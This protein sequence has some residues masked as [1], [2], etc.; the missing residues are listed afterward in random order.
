MPKLRTETSVDPSLGPCQCTHS[1]WTCISK[2]F[3]PSFRAFPQNGYGTHK[4][5]G[6]WFFEIRNY[7]RI[8]I[9]HSR[10]WMISCFRRVSL[11]E[12]RMPS[13]LEQWHQESLSPDSY[14]SSSSDR[15]S[16]DDDDVR[17]C[18]S[19]SGGDSRPSTGDSP[20]P[21]EDTS[22]CDTK[23]T[24]TKTVNNN[25]NLEYQIEN[26]DKSW[27]ETGAPFLWRRNCKNNNIPWTF[28][29]ISS[30]HSLFSREKGLFWF[31]PSLFSRQAKVQK[32][33]SLVTNL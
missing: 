26:S 32:C 19:T 13:L 21:E 22:H 18:A 8:R 20:Q 9:E 3:R 24:S 16:R 30:Y 12:G 2:N 1:K 33:L 10:G 17:D 25:N 7:K 31:K 23:K 11:Q 28:Q 5:P 15:T 29:F 14:V 4:L 6:L 27:R